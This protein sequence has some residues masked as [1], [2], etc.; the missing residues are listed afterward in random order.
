M[1]IADL[2]SERSLDVLIAGCG[3]GQHAIETGR[4][5][6]GASVLAVDLSLTSLSY[7]FRKTRELGLQNIAY[8]QA[9]ILKLGAIG[10]TSI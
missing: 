8:A 7:A 2:P 4:R 9:D 3:T 10:R 1:T 6:A 5:F